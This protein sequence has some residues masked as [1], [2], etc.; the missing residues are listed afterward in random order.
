MH[1]KRK[2]ERRE[3]NGEKKDMNSPPLI[4]SIVHLENIYWIAGH[5][6]TQMNQKNY[7]P[8]GPVNKIN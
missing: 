3:K 8:K 6:D 2:G 1:V 4:Y 7:S 5:A